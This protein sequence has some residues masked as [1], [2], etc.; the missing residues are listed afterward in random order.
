V[1]KVLSVLS[2]LALV[3]AGTLSADQTP[4][5]STHYVLGSDGVMTQAGTNV[6]AANAGHW[7]LNVDG[8]FGGAGNISSD[9]VFGGG[10][11][12]EYLFSPVASTDYGVDLD[13]LA[14]SVGKE[15]GG[16]S[17]GDIQISVRGIEKLNDMISFFVQAGLGYNTTPN[18]VNAHYQGFLEPGLRFELMP[19]LGI[20]V[21][22]RYA[23]LSPRD[24]MVAEFTGRIGVSIPLDGPFPVGIVK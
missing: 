21:G 4:T 17:D 18:I 1:N 10:A 7:L 6:T 3:G 15:S 11:G 8:E 12:I 24:H 22:A 16:T 2:V 23:E 20:D 19:R 13:Y 9:S 14:T 5:A